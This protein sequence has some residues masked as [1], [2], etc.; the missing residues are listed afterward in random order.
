[1][2]VDEELNELTS[3]IL[4]ELYAVAAV[5]TLFP[6]LRVACVRNCQCGA[7]FPMPNSMHVASGRDAKPG[8]VLMSKAASLITRN[9]KLWQWTGLCYSTAEQ[10]EEQHMPQPRFT[11]QEERVCT[12]IH[13]CVYMMEVHDNLLP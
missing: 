11:V 7:S 6:R 5:W 9:G 1:M 12:V 2:F 13:V 10:Y 3:D 8:S 4:P